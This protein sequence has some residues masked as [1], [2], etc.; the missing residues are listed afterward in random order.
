MEH[1]IYFKKKHNLIV[2]CRKIAQVRSILGA[3]EQAAYDSQ[4][5]KT[6]GEKSKTAEGP[7]VHA[8][9][10]RV[11]ISGGKTFGRRL[12]AAAD[13]EFDPHKAANS[14]PTRNKGRSPRFVISSYE[15]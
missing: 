5:Q 13:P 11:P 1:D 8:L 4:R 6:S 12:P 3:E 14:S 9:T 2:S 15:S 10:N 7:V